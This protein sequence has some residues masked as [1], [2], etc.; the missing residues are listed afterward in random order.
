MQELSQTQAPLLEALTALAK[1]DRAAFHTPGHKQG[2]STPPQ[3]S[4]LLGAALRADLPELPELDNLFAPEGVIQQ[5][6]FLA[7]EAFGAEQTWFLVNGSTSGIEAAVLATCGPGDKLILPRN[8]HQSA[9]SALILSGAIPIW[10]E[11]AYDANWQLAHCPTPDRIAEALTAHPNAKAILIVSPTYYGVCGDIAPIAQLAHAHNLPLLIDEA[12][13]AHFAFHPNLPTPALLTGADLVVQSIH[14]TL[15]ALTQAAM[16]HV[17]GSRIDRNRLSK[18]LQIIQSSSPNY[19]LLASLDAARQQ[20]ATQGEILME[21]TLQLA[22]Q[23][24]QQ[25]SQIP[26]IAVLSSQHVNP[27]LGFFDLD[28]TRLTVD[29]TELGLTGFEAD[30]ILH[31]K[32]GVTAELPT[33]NHLTFILSLGNTETDIERLVQALQQLATQQAKKSG[34]GQDAATNLIQSVQ[35]A[36]LPMVCSP[37]EA[38][39]APTQTLPIEAAI[40]QIS[41]ELVCPYPPGIP[42]LFPGEAVTVEAVH[43]LQQVLSNGGILTG[44]ADPALTTL[45]VVCEIE[46]WGGGEVQKGVGD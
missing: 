35:R 16:L 7:A 4:Q 20:M 44:C 12:H 6:Q 11:P 31:P 1:R 2:Q 30:E 43:Y 26:G 5:A 32:L 39:F 24:R 13:G 19:L 9:I 46:K 45:K 27:T 3:L 37:R 10:V 23:A 34:A 29:V 21:Q 22:Q 42:L 33:L 17:Q 15:S 18:A 36:A 38:F 41:A 28:L 8:A 25:L 14:K 40:H